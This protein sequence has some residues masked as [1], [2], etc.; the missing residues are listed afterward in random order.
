MSSLSS[1]SAI[2]PLVSTIERHARGRL[3]SRAQLRALVVL[4]ISAAVL[5]MA[6]PA[7]VSG[8][9]GDAPGRPTNLTG[10]VAH[11]AVKLWW[12]APEDSTVTG[13]QILR[14]DRAVHA[15]GDFQ[16]HV[17]DTGSAD[18]SYTD[19]DVEPEARYVYRVK[20]RNGDAVGPQSSYFDADLPAPPVPARPTGLTGNVTAD[21][22][23]LSWDDPQDDLITGYQILRLNRAEHALGDF[24]VH[25]ED[26][27]SAD[28]SYTDTDVEPRAEYVY[29]IKARNSAGLS[30]QSGYFDATVPAQPAIVTVSFEQA[31][32]TVREGESVV[33]AVVLDK[34]PE[35]AV[36][37]EIVPT[38]Q[39]G[40]TDS[41]YSGV[42]SEVAFAAGETRKEFTI[43]AA[44]DTEDDDGESVLLQFGA[45][46]PSNVRAGAAN[47]AE[48]SITD[49]D[50]VET[51]D[52]ASD[53]ST[54]CTLGVGHNGYGS[55]SSSRDD[56]LWSVTLAAG[57]AYQVE[58]RGA[59][60]RVAEENGGTLPD[61]RAALY[62][63]DRFLVKNNNI[64]GTA[65]RNSRMVYTV[66]SRA[67]GTYL[68]LI[69]G[70]GQGGSYTLT[71]TSLG[72][73]DY[74][75]T[76]ES[77]V[78]VPRRGQPPGQTDWA[79]GRIDFAGD[80]DFIGMVGYDFH[81]GGRYRIEFRSDE[82]ELDDIRV[83]AR[84]HGGLFIDG[85]PDPSYE[86][87]HSQFDSSG[88][89][90][91]HHRPLP[92]LSRDG[93]TV[94]YH[95]APHINGGFIVE[96]W[97][98]A[99]SNLGAYEVRVV[100]DPLP[101]NGSSEIH[102]DDLEGSADTRA[103]IADLTPEF[104]SFTGSYTFMGDDDWYEFEIENGK[105]YTFQVNSNGSD[106][107]LTMYDGDGDLVTR[108][109]GGTQATIV[110]E[111]SSGTEKVYISISHGTV[112]S[113]GLIEVSTAFN[114]RYTLKAKAE[115]T[116]QAE[117]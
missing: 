82:L 71:V 65:N 80:R 45:V 84:Q 39:N 53:A 31:T 73:D 102:H 22:V 33:V 28:T 38:N 56:D 55:L 101:W 76:Y 64:D 46:Q 8:Q 51:A 18:T 44:D 85:D 92:R 15:V 36:E 27:G 110:H 25:V 54:T 16:V 7:P 24:Q 5:V 4:T 6:G 41:E 104:R 67:A 96:V 107:L 106:L 70:G 93:N 98:R 103:K 52:C 42:P 86:L 109:T 97:S 49:N 90:Q 48:V 2:A 83:R 91:P 20:A 114:N 116:T 12:D 9:Q 88:D 99:D 95:V 87:Q 115:P 11:D 30:P 58:V 19:T 68:V 63:G 113:E 77:K 47:Q 1:A 61:P 108:S 35:G 100:R 75:Q 37:V 81:R 66:T 72:D 14:L 117:E 112:S 23:S 26:T 10:A 50:T 105:T 62:R 59:G 57:Q 69:R 17:D 34:D 78:K 111:H 21:Q 94:S 13:Y 60:S 3:P 29:R 32:Y 43:T 40:A 74:G 89:G 79:A